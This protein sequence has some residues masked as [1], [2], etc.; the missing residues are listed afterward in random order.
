MK[1]EKPMTTIYRPNGVDWLNCA[2]SKNNPYTYH[3]IMKAVYSGPISL[4]N[5]AILTSSP[6]NWLHRVEQNQ[7]VCY[8]RLNELF[9]WL[10]ETKAPPTV[11]YWLELKHLLEYYGRQVNDDVKGRGD[12]KYQ[13]SN[14][15][16]RQQKD[17]YTLQLKPSYQKESWEW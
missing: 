10:N 12:S 11:E 3:H 9:K 14:E 15:W 17:D 7:L 16:C 4:D 13:G 1:L 6:H 5:G 2:V 8:N